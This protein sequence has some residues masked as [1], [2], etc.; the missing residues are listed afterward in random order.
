M[1]SYAFVPAGR[2]CKKRMT[3]AETLWAGRAGLV[4]SQGRNALFTGKTLAGFTV[5]QAVFHALER[6][7]VRRW[8]AMPIALA[9]REHAVPCA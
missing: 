8:D 9:V 3:M 4:H 7:T 6:V 2:A 5:E 1:L